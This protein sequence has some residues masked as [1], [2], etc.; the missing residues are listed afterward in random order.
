MGVRETRP[1][2]KKEEDADNWEWE[3]GE[4]KK[5]EEKRETDSERAMIEGEDKDETD[6]SEAKRG[7]EQDTRKEGQERGEG[8]EKVGET[9]TT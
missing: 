2:G 3:T 5:R 9:R 1:D 4:R 8:R 6:M 7:T